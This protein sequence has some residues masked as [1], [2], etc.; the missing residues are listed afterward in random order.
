MA[1]IKSFDDF[2]TD[3]DPNGEH[4]FGSLDFAGTRLFWKIDL[5]DETYSYGSPEPTDLAKTRRVL[6]IMLPQEY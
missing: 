5:Y 1:A 6:T 2:S 3:N 4:D